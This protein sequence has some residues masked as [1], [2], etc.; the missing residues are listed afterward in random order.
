MFEDFFGFVVPTANHVRLLIFNL[1]LFVLFV[2]HL[3]ESA[4]TGLELPKI[5]LSDLQSFINNVKNE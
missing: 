2:I 1:R 5:S 3:H 4:R